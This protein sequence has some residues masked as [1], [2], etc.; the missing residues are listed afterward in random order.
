MNT[1]VLKVHSL[2]VSLTPH[3]HMFQIMQGVS[4]SLIKP[5]ESHEDV[6]SSTQF[7]L[8]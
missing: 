6:E 1:L 4:V 7:I 5:E 3:S 2:G 8:K